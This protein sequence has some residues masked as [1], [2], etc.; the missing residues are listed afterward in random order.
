MFL[1]QFG[2]CL[3]GTWVWPVQLSD[4]LFSDVVEFLDG[5]CVWPYVLLVEECCPVLCVVFEF[6]L[7]VRYVEFVEV[8]VQLFK[9]YWVSVVL[10]G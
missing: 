7:R 3:F 5:G 2:Q 4:G 6:A 10:D 1:V 9:V 8:A